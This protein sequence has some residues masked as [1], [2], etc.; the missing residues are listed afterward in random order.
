MAYA[1]EELAQIVLNE[2]KNERESVLLIM[3]DTL[4]PFR[5]P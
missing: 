4:Y 5:I 3:N 1:K 2:D